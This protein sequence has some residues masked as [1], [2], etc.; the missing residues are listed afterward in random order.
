[1]R[2]SDLVELAVGVGLVDLLLGDQTGS[3]AWVT[4]RA[5]V[6]PWST[7]S[8]LTSLRTTGMPA[9][10]T[11]WAISPP[12]VPAPT[13]AALKTNIGRR[14]TKKNARSRPSRLL[15]ASVPSMSRRLVLER[16][17]HVAVLWAL[18]VAGPLFDTA[19]RQ[20]GVLR[21]ASLVAGGDRGVCAARH[22]RPAAGGAR[23]RVAGRAGE[24][25][26]RLGVARGVRGRARRRRSCSACSSSAP[27]RRWRWRWSPGSP[28]PWSTCASRRRG[29]C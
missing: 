19:G 11:T 28:R 8:C 18:A 20:S 23:R 17:V 2:P 27:R 29:R 5:L 14:L 21:R 1:M 12:M 24:R 7:N 22:V 6:R 25:G 3:W 26:G 9:E 4:S 16:G 13:T 15:A 10:A